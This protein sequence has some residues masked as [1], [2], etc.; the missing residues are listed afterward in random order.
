MQSN[1]KQ[2]GH[3]SHP[4]EAFNIQLSTQLRTIHENPAV[5]RKQKSF[6][7]IQRGENEPVKLSPASVAD[8][9]RVK[10]PTFNSNLDKQQYLCW[11]LAATSSSLETQGAA[12]QSLAQLRC[13]TSL[14]MTRPPKPQC[15]VHTAPEVQQSLIGPGPLSCEINKTKNLKFEHMNMDEDT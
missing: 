2:S 5:A 14:D 3:K 12:A 11:V 1:I 13:E 8:T 10:P 7:M 15:A 9:E 6:T 4:C